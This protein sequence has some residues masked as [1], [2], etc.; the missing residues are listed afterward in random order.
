MGADMQLPKV[1]P[2]EEFFFRT[3]FA[4]SY[5]SGVDPE[6]F[7]VICK[8]AAMAVSQSSGN[9]VIVTTTNANDELVLR[10]TR[11]FAGEMTLREMT[12]LSQR[13]A[14]NNFFIELTDVLGDNLPFTMGSATAI[15]VTFP[16]GHPWNDANVGQF[17]NLGC[18]MGLAG[19][20][21]G[22]YAIASIS[23]NDVTF[24]VAGFPV[25]G[26]GTCS[27]YG[28]NY[29]RIL[30]DGTTATSAKFDSQ[31]NGWNTGDSTITINTSA[32]PGHLAALNIEDGVASIF[33]QLVATSTSMQLSARGSR[34]QNIPS[35]DTQLFIQ[36]RAVNGSTNPASATTWTVGL[37]SLEQYT[38]KRVSVSA[39][40]PQSYNHALPV[41]FPLTPTVTAT[42]VAGTAAHDAAVSGN[43]VL[44]GVEAR[45][46]NPAAVS[47][48][49][50]TARAIATM[51][52]VPVVMPH[53]IPESTWQYAAASGGI[54]NTTDV[55]IKA[56]AAA[57]IR[58]YLTG[59][60]IRNQ[61][62]SV[63]TEVVVKDGSTVIWRGHF[64]ANSPHV[65]VNFP[66][67]LRG[68]AA[69][70]LNVACITTGAAVYVNA[71]GYIAP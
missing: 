50:D 8:A 5:A 12:T 13:I 52:G 69:T 23:G 34:V 62:A 15:T 25:S 16:S 48:S 1:S 10:S 18:F 46:S 4:R 11:P 40:R 38:P 6:Y 45:T 39:V 64:N 2:E 65:F 49:G 66:I 35:N 21:P 33:D 59:I 14:N 70:A 27:V 54:V 68:T 43:P 37:I 31:R 17:V 20:I 7:N 42:G 26:S 41:V 28:W 32:S 29:Y 53:S 67:P 61:H 60:D 9:L 63:A 44:A 47:A 58:N 51:I 22:R 36:I 24:T 19:V 56:A 57:G 55:A 3:S 30:Y 71:Q